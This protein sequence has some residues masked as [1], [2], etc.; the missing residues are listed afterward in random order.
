MRKYNFDRYCKKNL[1]I[2]GLKNVKINCKKAI[3]KKPRPSG[4]WKTFFILTKSKWDRYL[5][6]GIIKKMG[7]RKYS[8]K[9]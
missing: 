3:R 9:I 1:S 8:L 6:D 7:E 5:K 4:D 2:F